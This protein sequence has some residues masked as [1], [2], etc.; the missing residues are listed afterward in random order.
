MDE[1][2]RALQKAYAQA[3]REHHAK[4]GSLARGYDDGGFVDDGGDVNAFDPGNQGMDFPPPEQPAPAAPDPMSQPSELGGTQDDWKQQA[5]PDPLP[6]QQQ[7]MAQPVGP[8]PDQQ[9]TLPPAINYAQNY[10]P[11]TPTAPQMPQARP[12]GL[13]AEPVPQGLPP[14]QS[15]APPPP[16]VPSNAF[17]GP[18]LPQGV[19]AQGQPQPQARN[20]APSF[21]TIPDMLQNSP[22]GVPLGNMVKAVQGVRQGPGGIGGGQPVY[23]ARGGNAQQAMQYLTQH[24]GWAPDK[25]A[26]MVWNLQQESGANLQTNLIHDQGTGYGI[27]G[28]RNERRAALFNYTGTNNPSLQQQLDFMVHELGTTESGAARRI[29]AAE[30]PADKARAAITYFRPAPQY[31]AARARNAGGVMGLLNGQGGGGEDQSGNVTTAAYTPDGRAPPAGRFASPD[32]AQPQPG[33]GG[34]GYGGGQQ[35][36]RQPRQGQ[37]QGQQLTTGQRLMRMGASIAGNRGGLGTALAQGLNAGFGGGNGSGGD[38]DLRTHAGMNNRVNGLMK[39]AK[40]HLRAYQAV[41]ED[42]AAVDAANNKQQREG[43]P[44]RMVRTQGQPQPGGNSMNNI[45]LS[46]IPAGATFTNAPIRQNTGSDIN[47]G[48]LGNG[49]P[50]RQAQGPTPDILADATDPRLDPAQQVQQRQQAT[51][52]A[53]SGYGGIGAAQAAPRPAPKSSSGGYPVGQT[54]RVNGK[55][56]KKVRDGDDKDARNWQPQ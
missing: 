13:G 18:P 43:V 46:P 49:P 51:A 37:G 29:N 22:L 14:L 39:Q 10:G 47:S 36:Q 26:A 52:T 6:P 32:Q 35:Q 21:G 31:A 23:G 19:P 15:M 4:R 30:T 28:F 45:P 41:P 34:G 54:V 11:P 9:P 56:Y 8:K 40:Q 50:L 3:L 55:T 20:N 27:A 1:K 44:V 12:P 53:D 33:G 48:V 2:L 17:T 5:P 7:D 16:P 38:T 25:A 24:Y 42:V